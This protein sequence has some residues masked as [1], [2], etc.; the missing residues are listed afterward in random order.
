[1]I[2]PG[3][4]WGPRAARQARA[5]GG[6]LIGC[7]TGLLSA[8]FACG[9]ASGTSGGARSDPP[10]AA[11]RSVPSPAKRRV[12]A[13]LQRAAAQVARLRK[14]PVL[15]EIRSEKL[16]RAA[17][18]QRVHEQMRRETPPE[19]IEGQTRLLRLL[20]LVGQDFEYVGAF[21]SL[22]EQQLAGFYDP[23]QKTMFV[24]ADLP[25]FGEQETVTHELVH[26]LQDQHFRLG[27]ELERRRNT[28]DALT[29][30]HLL[31]EGDAM[32]VTL[33]AQLAEQGVGLTQL[34]PAMVAD[35]IRRSIEALHPEVPGIVKRAAVAPYADGFTF[36][37][38]LR[39]DGDWERVDEAWRRPPR[40]TEQA[41][42][43][44]KYIQDEG[45]R[46]L[47]ALGDG[48]WSSCRLVYAEMLGEQAV[49]L[50][51][52]EWLT[53][54]E[55]RAASSGWNGDRASVFDCGVA[56]EALVWRLAYDDEPSQQRGL[57]TLRQLWTGCPNEGGKLRS[58][59]QLGDEVVVV[60][61]GGSVATCS[62]LSGWF[63]ALGDD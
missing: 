53:T 28:S 6:L 4:E 25:R 27:A 24:A 10:A 12:D 56:G 1:M 14:L 50:V 15:E 62:T 41:L 31:A 58:V 21:V 45:W 38:M 42:H 63:T 52:A 47:A 2:R 11:T 7:V 57:A 13:D 5:P 33:E 55:A 44:E 19:W 3:G 49:A 26:A 17:L 61:L 54:D 60:A 35:Q 59:R 40:S 37:Q 29:A 18:A 22:L 23:T 51:L 30:L 32:S 16:P 46:E 48:P 43:L 34:D 39:R 36:V 20:G 9:G 8:G